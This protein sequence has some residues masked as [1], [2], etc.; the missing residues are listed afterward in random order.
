M[1]DMLKAAR[2]LQTPGV[3]VVPQPAVCILAPN[4]RFVS[5]PEYVSFTT[6]ALARDA[7]D[8]IASASKSIDAESSLFLS[9]WLQQVGLSLGSFSSAVKKTFRVDS[10]SLLS[11]CADTRRVD[12]TLTP[13]PDRVVDFTRPFPH[14]VAV[15]PATLHASLPRSLS[16]RVAVLLTFLSRQGGR[17]VPTLSREGYGPPCDPPRL[18]RSLPT[19]PPHDAAPRPCSARRAASVAP[20]PVRPLAADQMNAYKYPALC[21]RYR[22]SRPYLTQNERYKYPALCNRYRTNRPYLTQNERYKYP[23]LCNRYRTNRPYLTQNERHKYPALCNRYR[24][25]RP[26][27]TQNERYKSPALCNRYRTNRPYLTQNERHKYPALCN[28]YL[29]QNERYKSPSPRASYRHDG[30][31]DLLQNCSQKASAR[32]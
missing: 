25:S 11:F 10:S 16:V 5:T 29:T 12:S 18:D 8:T 3:R 1:T 7:P 15:L 24:T 23:A 14:R 31:L 19:F 17:F 9:R 26:Y 21:N 2:L 6:A 13:F 32:L 28:M 27:L 4:V 20:P 22:I 30:A